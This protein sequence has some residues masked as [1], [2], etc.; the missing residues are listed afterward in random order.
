VR[1]R[2]FPVTAAALL[3]VI[4][5]ACSADDSEGAQ[6]GPSTAPDVLVVT[7]EPGTPVDPPAEPTTA[8]VAPTAP[9][10]PAV[11]LRCDGQPSETGRVRAPLT[12]TSGIT[13]SRLDPGTFWVHND[14]GDAPRAFRIDLSGEIVEE[15]SLP[16]ASAIDWEDI[17]SSPDGTI[18]LADT[19]DNF[20]FRP[21]VR[22]Y[23]FREDGTG[24]TEIRRFTYPDG[25]QDVEA[26]AVDPVEG[27]VFV[28]SKGDSSTVYRVPEDGGDAEVVATLPLATVT[29]AELSPDG[30]TLAVHTLRTTHLWRR[31]SVD[32]PWSEVLARTADC[33]I[34]AG[35]GEA[36]T[37]TL[38]GASLV[39]VAE[40]DGSPLLV[41]PIA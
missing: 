15:R 14:S 20:R 24:D 23:G 22:L 28:F 7:T 16:D 12:E 9:L 11:P 40:G 18:W 38:D 29:A 36:V 17:S 25:P 26:L 32:E 33:S 6:P 13:P 3:A 39:T 35:P 8:P 41:T 19:G 4:A 27:T 1:S 34:D 21:S 30:V 10:A 31:A 5:G 37:F 2:R